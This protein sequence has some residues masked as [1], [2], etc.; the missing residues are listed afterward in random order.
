MKILWT[1]NLI[2]SPCASQLGIS[3]EVLGGWVE[4]MSA[5]IIKFENIF[6]AIACKC[7]NMS[8]DETVGHIRY[9]SLSY[10]GKNDYDK[11][12]LQCKKIIDIISP[13]IIHIEGTEFI[14]SKAMLDVAN[15]LNIPA[16]VSLQGILNGQYNYQCGQLQ[17]DDMLLSGNPVNIFAGA[18]M[19]FRKT[20]WY[21][22][23]MKAEREIIENAKYILGRT[24][25][26]RAHSYAINPEAK[27]FSVPRVLRKPFYNTHWDI[28]KMQPHSIYV[29]NGYY[30]LKGLHYLVMA[31]PLLAREYPDLKIYVAGYKPYE[32]NDNRSIIK[33]GYA[34][35]LKKLI[36]DLDAEKYIEFTGPLSA[37]QVAEKLASV[38]CYVLTSAIENSP[39][40]LAEAMLVGTPCVAAYV[41]GVP[42]M[43]KDGEEA[44]L[45]RNDDYKFLAWHIKQIFDNNFLISNLSKNASIKAL[46]LYSP[47]VNANKLLEV[48]NS[49]I[50]ISL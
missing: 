6:L 26:D 8:F 37:Q 47:S 10:S 40:T 21:K 24:T 33:K 11:L 14:H 34:A 19:H 25:W 1:V 38:N 23:R 42:D 50:G 31:I 5:E 18:I 46:S 9:F 44:L 20:R 48:Y 36:R 22:P 39:N 41:G 3:R 4:A 32:K 45:Y 30:P 49:I 43:A 7:D 28:N 29:G 35:Y 12:C 2:P 15:R 27:Y 13:D 17:I 16:V